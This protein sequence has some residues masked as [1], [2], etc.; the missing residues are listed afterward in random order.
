MKVCSKC[1]ERKSTNKFNRNRSTPDGYD[2]WCK[3][4]RARYRASPAGRRSTRK[5]TARYRKT[6]RGQESKRRIDARHGLT[7]SRKRTAR[8]ATRRHRF[9]KAG[10]EG[11]HTAA[12]WFALCEA[13]GFRCLSH[14]KH[15]PLEDDVFPFGE[16]TEDHVIPLRLGGDDYISNIQP[17]CGPCN[18]RKGTK[19]TDHRK[20]VARSPLRGMQ[21]ELPF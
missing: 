1:R 19:T 15:F 11:T 18:A 14:K 12:E 7:E 3:A 4:C 21:L 10:A 9:R 16:L 5:S 6:G 20:E 17:L 2:Y 13:Y 8:Q